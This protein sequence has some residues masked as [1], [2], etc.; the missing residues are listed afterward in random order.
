MNFRRNWSVQLLESKGNFESRE[1]WNKFSPLNEMLNLWVPR[2]TIPCVG[3][4]RIYSLAISMLFV[5]R[6]S[7]PF[8]TFDTCWA[9]C[10]RCAGIQWASGS[11]ASTSFPGNG[12]K[13]RW[14][15]LTGGHCRRVV[16]CDVL[17]C[18]KGT[19]TAR[20]RLF[21][22]WAV[23]DLC[24]K[25]NWTWID[26]ILDVAS[27]AWHLRRLKQ[28]RW[29]FCRRNCLRR[30]ESVACRQVSLNRQKM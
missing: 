23:H 5:M 20:L 16:T 12:C 28:C 6:C 17:M 11:K 27:L 4:V 18:K 30:V 13:R 3:S 15:R 19:G 9:C 7:L 22:F 1:I 14:E 24:L 8:Q 10:V 26:F 25:L 21:A 29:T 2:R